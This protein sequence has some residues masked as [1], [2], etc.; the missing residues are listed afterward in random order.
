VKGLGG[1]STERVR[2]PAHGR[3]T[4]RMTFNESPAEVDVNDGTVPEVEDSIH[5]KILPPQ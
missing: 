2:I 3:I 4:Y 1:S 5:R